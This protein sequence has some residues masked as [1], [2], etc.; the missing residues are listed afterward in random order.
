MNMAAKIQLKA[1]HNPTR[2]LNGLSGLR[3]EGTVKKLNKSMTFPCQIFLL[4]RQNMQVVR[5]TLS[6]QKGNYEFLSVVQN[7]SYAIIA[8]DP[9]R[10]YNAVIQDMV[11]PK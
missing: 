6:D 4:D 8:I 7:F 5:R 11:V 9:V 10:K 3:L 1:W 2:S